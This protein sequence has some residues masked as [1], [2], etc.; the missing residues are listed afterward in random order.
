METLI[1]HHTIAVGGIDLRG[2]TRSFGAVHAVRGIDLAV[3]PG[4]SVAL[5][6]PNGAGK[7]TTID[8]I[9]GLLEP[10][11]GGVTLFGQQPH[12][13]IADG[14]VG[15]MLQTGSLV[16][17]LSVRELVDMTASLYA[18]AAARRRCPLPQRH[19]VDRRPAHAEAV[20]RGGAAG[21]LCG[22]RRRRP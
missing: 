2:V 22:R 8:I 16:R 15:A 11:G 3:A 6:G 18:L 19:D 4:E 12:A 17:D 10:D 14:R 1:P 5:L 21:P 20:G 13:A 7:S 9:L